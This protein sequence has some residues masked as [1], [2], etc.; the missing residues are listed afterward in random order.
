[1]IQLEIGLTVTGWN[2]RKIKTLKKHI[3]HSVNAVKV[4]KTNHAKSGCNTLKYSCL[5]KA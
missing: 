1:M 2:D 3:V 4:Y 5:L